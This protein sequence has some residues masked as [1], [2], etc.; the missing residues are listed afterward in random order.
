MRC[1]PVNHGSR[2]GLAL[3][4]LAASSA[5][6]VLFS[7]Q[8]HPLTGR[9]IAP[10]MGVGGAEWLERAER[11]REEAPE[12]AVD[13]LGLRAGMTVADVGAG[14]G[15]FTLRL[16]R[17][18]APNGKVYASDIQPAMLELLR[19]RVEKEKLAIV[20][21]VLGTET[22]PRLPAGRIELALLVDVYHEFSRPQEM[23]RKLREALT[24]DGRL[25]L[26][27]YRKED[28]AV[29]IRFEHKMS[30]AEVKTEI[31]AEGFRLETLLGHLPRQHLLVFRKRDREN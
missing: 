25:V 29:P 13:A 18:V 31:E 26:L 17:R 7:Q 20:E 10:V 15:Y 3:V 16:A 28:P 5:P 6:L 19:K 11:E 9:R 22:D 23:L 2:P 30:V 21:P 27:E 12:A 14:S 24:G 8:E 1:T 4:L